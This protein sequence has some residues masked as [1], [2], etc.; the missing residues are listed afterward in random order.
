MSLLTHEPRI[1]VKAFPSVPSLADLPEIQQEHGSI[2][3]VSSLQGSIG[4]LDLA[5]GCFLTKSLKYTH[6]LVHWINAVHSG[7]EVVSKS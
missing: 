1:T 4:G 3:D 6:S 2:S 7:R 5:E